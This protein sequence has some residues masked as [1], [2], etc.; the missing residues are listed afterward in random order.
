MI[1]SDFI[2]EKITRLRM[3]KGVSE[4]EM[5]YALGH[6]RSYIYNISSGR[7]LPTLEGFLEICEYLEVSP[8]AFF[9]D[10]PA[11]TVPEDYRELLSILQNLNK[12]DIALVLAL[13]RRLSKK[14]LGGGV[15]F[16]E[17]FAYTED[18]QEID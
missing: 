17:S 15:D 14:H 12:D 18:S 13:S 9:S 16:G 4:Y 6:S 2:R 1:D 5:S 7:C 10:G 11:G 3:R 8:V